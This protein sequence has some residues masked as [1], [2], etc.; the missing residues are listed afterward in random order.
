MRMTAAKSRI[1]GE[2]K[3][4][5]YI[6]FSVEDNGMGMNED[7][8]GVIYLKDNNK[9]PKHGSGVGLINVHSRIQSDVWK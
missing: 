5:R 1:R 4:R 8:V 9:V 7:I 3:G 2:K 6:Y